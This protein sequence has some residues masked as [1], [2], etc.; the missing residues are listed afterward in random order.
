MKESQMLRLLRT[1]P[2]LRSAQPLVP[3]SAVRRSPR[4]MPT[5][6]AASTAILFWLSFFPANQ[7]WCAW[8]ALVALLIL[9]R[10]QMSTRAAAL[11]GWLIALPLFVASLQWVRL[12]HLS[13]YAAWIALAF[14]CSL[15]FPLTIWLLRR[16]DRLPG[17]P[18][19]LSLPVVWTALEYFRAHFVWGFAWYFLGHTQHDFLPMIQVADLGGVYVISFLVAAG[20]GLLFGPL[21]RWHPFRRW[22]RIAL[23]SP[24]PLLIPGAVIA[25]LMIGTLG[26]GWARRGQTNFRG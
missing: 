8:F 9:V 17:V 2:A 25:V 16:L 22:T 24:K 19:A 23:A 6:L 18:L 3:E 1:L 13:M 12:A 21:C 7:G 15:Y 4:Y 20:N 14:Y 11:T 26:Y 5:L 10:S